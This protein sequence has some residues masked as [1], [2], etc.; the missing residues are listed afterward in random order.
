MDAVIAGNGVRKFA[1]DG[2]PAVSASLDVHFNAGLAVDGGGNVFFS[3]TNNNRVRRVD[4]TSRV[5]TT[6]FAIYRPTGLALDSSGTLY[7]ATGGAVLRIDGGSGVVVA[8]GGSPATGIGDEGPAT[9]ASLLNANA[10]AFDQNDNLFIADASHNRIRRVDHA[11]QLITT[12]AGN[13]GSGAPIDGVAA[14]SSPV[15]QP[16]AI[17]VDAAGNLHI[18]E[19][20]LRKVDALTGIISTL[21]LNLAQEVAVGG[22]TIY[23]SS[24]YRVFALESVAEADRV[25]AG[26]GNCCISG[27]GGPAADAKLGLPL[28]VGVDDDENVYISTDWTPIRKVDKV[29]GSITTIPSVPNAQMTTTDGAGNLFYEWA[30]LIYRRDA[31][32]G[33][34]SVVAGG[35]STLGEGG[36]ATSAR[37]NTVTALAVDD[38]GN[39]YF[40]DADY[41]RIRRVS[42]T[43]TITTIAGNGT[44]GFSGNGGPATEASIALNPYVI[45]GLA[46]GD[47]GTVFFSD[48]GNARVRAVTPTGEVAPVAGNGSNGF[49][50]DNGPATGAQFSCVTGLATDH[51]DHLFIIDACRSDGLGDGGNNRVRAVDLSTGTITSIAGTGIGG[52][53]GDGGPASAAQ[54]FAPT[55]IA[56]TATG[57]VV[58]A[59]RSTARIRIISASSVP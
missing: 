33:A 28:T 51:R 50:G 45:G 2:G 23:Y 36:S 20:R 44:Y 43:G 27:D 12:V 34:V 58:V 17:A 26:T 25:V 57:D 29:T 52:F 14:T 47:D 31:S 8:G 13:G 35:G 49:G 7:V 21:R 3:D 6:V 18:G 32:T 24:S 4:A 42:P 15:Y 56:T 9:Q 10:I 30:N 11:T 54:L 37:V 22:S 40:A 46:I 41:D 39:V 59:D 48:Y 19:Q 53:S 1:G 16:H 38:A 55:G 5:I